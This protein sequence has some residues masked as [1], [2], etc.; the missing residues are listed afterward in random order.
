[1]VSEV[2]D[3]VTGVFRRLR[4]DTAGRA[5]T[6]P[7]AKYEATPP[8]LVDGDVHGLTLTSDG[9]LRVDDPTTQAAIAAAYAAL[10]ATLTAIKGVGWTTET[11]KAIKDAVD[12]RL[13]AASYVTER[14]TD[15]ALLA[16]DYVAPVE[17]AALDPH[18]A[19][20]ASS[21]VTNGDVV[22]I[23][24]AGF[25]LGVSQLLKAYQYGTISGYVTVTIDGGSLGEMVMTVADF[26]GSFPGTPS[27]PSGRS[28]A[29]PL[30]FDTS[31]RVQHRVDN[32]SSTVRTLVS[33]VTE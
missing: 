4:G 1:M 18:V 3:Y 20:A 2:W 12:T 14:G 9:K 29:G 33:Y 32:T 21:I 13:A 27:G 19:D 6:L 17:W 26:A 15:N 23:N 11:L 22:N 5:E 28:I 25:L 16:A 24:G 31:L 10:A 30:R 8:A 7:S